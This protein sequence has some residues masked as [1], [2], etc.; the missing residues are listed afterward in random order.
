MR[1]VHGTAWRRRG[2]VAAI[3]ALCLT[4]PATAEA[5]R[6]LYFSGA[7]GLATLDIAGDGSLTQ[8]GAL[9]DV[10]AASGLAFT[11]SGRFL[12]APSP[13][14]NLFGF[15]VAAD[16]SLSPL[17]G[18]PFGKQNGTGS[19]TASPDGRRVYVP[20]QMQ[21][22]VAVFEIG[23]DGALTPAS[24][25]P[26]AAGDGPTSI[27]FTPDGSRAFVSNRLG[28]TIQPYTVG[29]DGS[30][31]AFGTAV[32]PGPQIFNLQ[33]TPDGARLYVARSGGAVHGY[34]VAATGGLT[35]ISGSPFAVAGT[36]IDLAVTPD[37]RHL[38]VPDIVGSNTFG[39]A[40]GSG[41]TLTALSGSPFNAVAMPRGLV[42]SP[43]SGL[44][45]Q[46]SLAG[47]LTAHTISAEGALTAVPGSPFPTPGNNSADIYSLAITPDQGPVAAMTQ[48]VDAPKRRVQFNAAGSADADGTVA[49][50]AFDFGDGQ[51]G[52]ASVPSITHTYE[53]PGVYTARL[54]VIDNE[55]CSFAYISTGQNVA[56]NGSAQA[57]TSVELDLLAPKI[58]FTGGR[59]QRLSRTI[60]VGLLSNEAARAQASARIS[61]PG[62]TGSRVGLRSFRTR[63]RSRNLTAGARGV[64]KLK[65][66]KPAFEA[67]SA[68]LAAGGKVSAKV[69]VVA[70]DASGNRSTKKRKLKL[71]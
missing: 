71:R 11:P 7:G 33:L 30:L 50:Y 15:A 67:A 41:G 51:T 56:C 26:V 59:K 36:T 38:Y 58:R 24:F 62:E 6:N 5:K 17:P 42:A 18:S 20:N 21:D 47:G 54:T 53:L 29:A 49:G 25:S 23:A 39:F 9:I 66:S 1:S 19:S 68:A 55:G 3:A 35:E 4:L 63:T 16:G 10:D 8:L 12:Y 28:G 60:K 48:V 57:T 37:G 43:N 32:A 27:V 13:G 34:D 61:V 52:F 65:L 22:S 2:W 45:Y 69:S 14:T 64:I 40:I 31:T 44:L 70:T 46:S